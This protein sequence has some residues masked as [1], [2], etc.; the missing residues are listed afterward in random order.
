MEEKIYKYAATSLFGLERF[1]GETIDALGYKRLDTIEGRVY[2]EGDISAVP[3][4]NINFR[5]AEKLFI[6]LDEFEATTFD[7]LFEGVKR[8]PWE[9]YIG[10]N[11]AFPVKGH[12]IKSRLHSIPDCQK[13]VKKAKKAYTNGDERFMCLCFKHVDKDKYA[14]LEDI[15][16]YIP[17][18][19]Q[20]YLNADEWASKYS[21]WWYVS[22]RESRF[23]AFDKLIELY[24]K[25]KRM[26]D[27][28]VI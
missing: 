17:E 16:K 28:C 1:V 9:K 14:C 6:I 23:K 22:D 11:D 20:T 19:N 21:Q 26:I 15:Q 13:I 25:K 27:I 18:F 8:I 24:S 12:S 7:E 2:F 10:K 5:C 3:R 4:C